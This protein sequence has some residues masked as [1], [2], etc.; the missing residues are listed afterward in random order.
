M[1]NNN[2]V[3]KNGLTVNGSFTANSTVVNAAAINASSVNVSTVNTSTIN[4]SSANIVTINAS[5]VNS[6][7][8]YVGGASVNTMIT[9]NAATAYANAVANSAA[10]YQT[11]AGLSA[12]VATLTSNNS[13]NF[14]GLSLATVQSQITGNAATA[15]SN[16][17]ANAAALY[18]NTSGAYTISGVHTH[19]ANIVSSATIASG[20][21]S[22]TTTNSVIVN[23]SSIYVGNNS[24]SAY[25]NATS[26]SGTSALATYALGASTNTFTIGTTGYFVSNG[27][28]GIGN[29]TPTSKLYVQGG[30]TLAGNLTLTDSGNTDGPNIVLQSNGYSDWN[31][32]SFTGILRMYNGVTERVRIGTGGSLSISSNASSAY[33]PGLLADPSGYLYIGNQDGA[34]G[35]S[36]MQFTRNGTSLGSI[37]QYGTTGVA[38]NTASDYRLKQNVQKLTN[39][40]QIIA[41][42]NP[43]SYEWKSDNTK[44]EGFIAHELQQYV[45]AAVTGQKD[46][47]DDDGNMK[48]QSVDYSKIVVHLVAAIQELKAEFDAYKASHP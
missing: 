6:V 1:A 4:A 3:V 38:Y 28:V 24:V 2:F 25:I 15:Y 48:L 9:G 35:F 8:L 10:L 34:N 19:S 18:V 39:S 30:A 33:N 29:S 21:T 42:L 44:G 36:Y 5:S 46:A 32:D 23:S 7:S 16:A 40:L 47:V 13:T 31:I 12:N 20:C 11:T 22:L 41:N 37:T 14:G 45:P 17:V 26:F 43:V 27:N